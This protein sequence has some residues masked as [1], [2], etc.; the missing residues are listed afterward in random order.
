MIHAKE[1]EGL[2]RRLNE[3]YE[4]HTGRTTRRSRMRSSAIDFLSPDEAKTFGLI[5]MRLRKTCG[6][7]TRLLK[8]CAR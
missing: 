4:K 2:K 3:I 1:V 8:I 5:D 6:T 7:R